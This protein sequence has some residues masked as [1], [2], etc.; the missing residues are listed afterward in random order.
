MQTCSS[1]MLTCSN[2]MD[3]LELF[4]RFRST[5]PLRD[6]A[7][8]VPLLGDML[9]TGHYMPAAN[10]VMS[11]GKGFSLRGMNA[12]WKTRIRP[13]DLDDGDIRVLFFPET[14][15]QGSERYYN[16][17]CNSGDSDSEQPEDCFPTTNV[18]SPQAASI[19]P[20]H[21]AL[22]RAP[23]VAEH[24]VYQGIG[25]PKF[26]RR[27]QHHLVHAGNLPSLDPVPSLSQAP[28]RH[29]TPEPDYLA[30]CAQ[31][32]TGQI[33]PHATTLQPAALST[34][35]PTQ[36]SFPEGSSPPSTVPRPH[37]SSTVP[38]GLAGLFRDLSLPSRAQE[39][40]PTSQPQNNSCDFAAN[41]DFVR[42]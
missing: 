5:A 29:A 35:S 33:I 10:F 13:H 4:A 21:S 40:N 15:R 18:P 30:A 8:V 16:N 28:S 38:R 3:K 39:P 6:S 37:R 22:R 32:T 9:R 7:N 12:L 42:L 14:F 36:W 11:Y 17:L 24:M 2:L 19:L 34:P 1:V 31:L 27:L 23:T 26:R 20:D 41:H 25:G